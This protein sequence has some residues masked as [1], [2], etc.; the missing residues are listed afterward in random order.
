L[1][2]LPL[3]GPVHEFDQGACQLAARRACSHHH[4]RL[5][6]AA[7]HR[8]G[9]L[10]RLFQGHQQSPPDL[11]GMLE[12]LHRR[13]HGPPLLPAEV[14]AAGAG[15]QQEMV[16]AIALVVEHHLPGLWID[17]HHLPQQDL[18]VGGLAHHLP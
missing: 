11:I 3:H 14:G 13:R 17:V 10:L 9:R 12:D 2:E 7:A 15:G 5:Q 1:L 6:E 18:D 4:H 16:V 8:I